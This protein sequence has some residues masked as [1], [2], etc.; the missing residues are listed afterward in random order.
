MG[1]LWF[2]IAMM[3]GERMRKQKIRQKMSVGV[4]SQK[5]GAM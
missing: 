5:D 4:R 3:K 1:N 2:R